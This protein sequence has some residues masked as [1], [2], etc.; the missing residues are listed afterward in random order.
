MK[1]LKDSHSVRGSDHVFI[2][3]MGGCSLYIILLVTVIITKAAE[4]GQ[5]C[6]SGIFQEPRRGQRG[7]TGSENYTTIANIPAHICTHIC[8]QRLNCSVI[9]YN[10]VYGN[11]QFTS[12]GCRNTTEDPA[13]VVTALDFPE[14]LPSTVRSCLQWVPA[15]DIDDDLTTPCYGDFVVARL[16]LPSD[17]LLGSFHRDQYGLRVWKNSHFYTSA[18]EGEVLHIHPD[19]PSTWEHYTP[20]DPIPADA[21][22]GGY[23]GDSCSG[24]PIIHGTTNGSRHVITRCGYYNPKT[25]QGFISFP[26]PANPVA[27][28]NIL[29]LYEPW[30][31][32]P[33]TWSPKLH[34]TLGHS[35]KIK[36]P[37]DEIQIQIIALQ[38]DYNH[39]VIDYIFILWPPNSMRGRAIMLPDK[40]REQGRLRKLPQR[41]QNTM[42][43]MGD[44]KEKG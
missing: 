27:Q 15:T 6:Q 43:H 34:H 33:K 21:V 30:I 14:C 1:V 42:Q 36:L 38:V 4:A 11:C 7:V 20:G 23:L 39:C 25:Q 35:L 40:P 31:E 32:N 19:C 12:E 8:M 41:Q 5:Q 26:A 18:V 24:T 10:H 17:V 13:F 2:F 16:V 9:N 37:I 44:E 28:M 3:Q 29:T 22:I